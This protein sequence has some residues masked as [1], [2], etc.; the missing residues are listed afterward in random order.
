MRMIVIG[1]GPI[2]G[3]I[4]GRLARAGHDL[5]F[6]DVDKE[7]VAAIRERGLQIDVPDGPFNVKT[8]VVFP[9]EIR[10]RFDIGFIAVRSNDTLDALDTVLPQLADNGLLVSMQNGIN[11]PLLEARVGPDRTVG[12]AIRMGSRR[13]APGHL[14]TATRGHLY[15]G[16]LHGRT[17]PQL[18]KL[19][20]LLDA[21]I[22]SE[23]SDNIFG[24]L[25]SK[26][27]YTCL[28]Y[29]GSLANASLAASCADEA[30]RRLLTD[31]F[32]E[33]VAVG[34]AAGARFIPLAEY[35]PPDLHPSNSFDKR[36]AAV[37]EMT[38]SWKL[39]DRKGP[40][41]QIQ[42]GIRTEVDFT[43]AH[44][45]REGERL[46]IPTPLCRRVL[47]MIHELE[48]GRRRL[49]RENY[50]ALRASPAA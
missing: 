2:G 24:V 9:D 7:H 10:G 30:G 13:L 35:N 17:T 20:A 37:D 27:T 15:V 18:E 43:L 34:A 21:V 14:H 1:T 5:T 38:K 41:R 22:P 36:L 3:I 4:G 39:D 25:W 31:F 50:A 26:L 47:E 33:I 19:N 46:K 32:A 49:G 6:V 40:L 48:T 8:D 12:V 28:G 42:K 29:F 23:I 44:V 16:H 11:P 45:V